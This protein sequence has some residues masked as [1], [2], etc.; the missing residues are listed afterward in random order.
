MSLKNAVE[1]TMADTDGARRFCDGQALK[2]HYS[3]PPFTDRDW[4][5]IAGNYVREDGYDFGIYCLQPQGAYAIDASPARGKADG[6]RRFCADQSG[7]VGCG[8]Q[9]SGSGNACIPCTQ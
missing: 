2:H 6:S 3:G 9:W 5:F 4:R 1:R 8:T 7:H